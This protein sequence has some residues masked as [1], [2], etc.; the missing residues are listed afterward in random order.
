[1]L[2]GCHHH[3]RRNNNNNFYNKAR[4][5][6]AAEQQHETTQFAFLSLATLL[7]L[8]VKTRPQ[9]NESLSP[10]VCKIQPTTEISNTVHSTA[11]PWLL[12][13][14]PPTAL[15]PRQL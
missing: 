5:T 8:Q 6:P 2:G 9:A 14:K 4:G 10:Q 3:R 15:L 1:V 12:Q 11:A 13:M 7:L